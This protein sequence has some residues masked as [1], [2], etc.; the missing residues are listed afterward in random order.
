MQMTQSM[1]WDS[2]RTFLKKHARFF[3]CLV[4]SLAAG[5]AAHAF[6]Y[7]GIGFSQDSLML[8]SNDV[9]WQIS[10]G[11]F[12]IPIYYYLRGRYTVPWLL[13]LYCM[14]YAAISA[15]LIASVMNIRKAGHLA[16][17]CCIILTNAAVTAQTA[18]YV[19]VIDIYMLGFLLA[20]LSVWLLWR[21][22]F[23]F[24]AGI[25]V[26]MMSVGLYP[27]YFAAAAGLC[28]LLVVKQL[29]DSAV[30][31][32]QLWCLI[33]KA[34][35]ML[36]AGLLLYAG[37]VQLALRLNG[38]AINQGYNGISG[39]GDFSNVSIVQLLIDLYGYVLRFLRIPTANQPNLIKW[40]NVLLMLAALVQLIRLLVRRR[41][42]WWR[43]LLT[44]VALLLLP[45]AAN[46]T[47]F[48][49][50][51][52]LHGVMTMPLY[53]LYLFFLLTHVWAQDAQPEQPEPPKRRCLRVISAAIIPALLCIW[54]VD[55]IQFSNASYLKKRLEAQS[56]VSV[57]TRVINRIEQTE[58]YQPGQTM[59]AFIGDLNLNKHLTPSRYSFEPLKYTGG[60]VPGYEYEFTVSYPWSYRYYMEYYLGYPMRMAHE[61][62]ISRLADTETVQ[63]MPDFPATDCVQ[64]VEDTLVVKLSDQSY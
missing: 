27:A 17:L 40:V 39:V 14:L 13:G 18:T 21:Y 52:M 62:E 12:M 56:T 32:K 7:T 38:T 49:S 29:L 23:G 60:R 20:S 22:R 4:A 43:V 51:G 61:G 3:F 57:M 5:L 1:D 33:G 30:S 59:V 47:Y 37:M 34:L 24:L 46:A 64:W 55:N 35:C 36:V 9:T 53:L 16:L 44:A 48:L 50:K 6:F 10:L 11:R 41:P 25:P 58:G 54:T 15:S 31:P 28:V 45:F 42:A 8:F 19:H 63:A 2:L 26:L